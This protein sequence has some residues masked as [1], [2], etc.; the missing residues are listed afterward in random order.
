M[1]GRASRKATAKSKPEGSVRTPRSGIEGESPRFCR[2]GRQLPIRGDP[3]LTIGELA[4]HAAQAEEMAVPPRS[5]APA[6]A[7]ASWGEDDLERGEETQGR[8]ESRPSRKARRGFGTRRRS[9]ASRPSESR[10][11]SRGRELATAHGAGESRTRRCPDGRTAQAVTKSG[12]SLGTS[13]AAQRSQG[14]WAQPLRRQEHPIRFSGRSRR[15]SGAGG[16][17][18]LWRSGQPARASPS[19]TQCDRC[20]VLVTG[21]GG[22][23]EALVDEPRKRRIRRELSSPGGG[24]SRKRTESLARCFRTRADPVG[25]HGGA[26]AR[27]QRAAATRYRLLTRTDSEGKAHCGEGLGSPERGVEQSTQPWV[28]GRETQ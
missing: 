17:W 2:M 23:G 9:K 14:S 5:G 16:R 28:S 3:R 20:P 26:T 22:D 7:G 12:V 4:V 10:R 21:D 13:W 24:G 11:T 8:S 1:A 6:R 18:W 25:S 15:A 27:G 19:E